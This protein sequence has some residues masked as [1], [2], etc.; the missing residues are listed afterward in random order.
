MLRAVQ[1]LQVIIFQM[2]V[3][4]AIVRSGWKGRQ[5][6]SGMEYSGN[7]GKYVELAEGLKMS[8]WE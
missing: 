4:R 1:E 2:C 6:V 7:K 3:G 5:R 8:V